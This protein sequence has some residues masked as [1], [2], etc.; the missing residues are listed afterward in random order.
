MPSTNTSLRYHTHSL[1]LAKRRVLFKVKEFSLIQKN[2]V[3][4]Q[5]LFLSCT[6]I[7]KLQISLSAS[8]DWLLSKKKS[9][10]KTVK[11]FFTGKLKNPQKQIRDLKIN[12]KFLQKVSDL[13]LDTPLW[14]VQWGVQHTAQYWAGVGWPSQKI[15]AQCSCIFKRQRSLALWPLIV[16]EFQYLKQSHC[17]EDVLVKILKGSL[18]MIKIG[19]P[20]NLE[21]YRRAVSTYPYTLVLVQVFRCCSKFIHI[22]CQMHCVFFTSLLLILASGEIIHRKQIG[23]LYTN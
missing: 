14:P 1:L 13:F 5:W 10:I 19:D 4:K 2:E 8:M 12:K 7:A 23:A 16:P 3:I 20:H 15:P 11:I 9:W 17:K 6:S 21:P 18:V 22:I